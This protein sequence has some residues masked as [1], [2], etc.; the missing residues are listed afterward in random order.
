MAQLPGDTRPSHSLR[1]PPTGGPHSQAPPNLPPLTTL[2]LNILR[3]LRLHW[4]SGMAPHLS[5]ARQRG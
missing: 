1:V 4:A 5:L 3:S 2:L